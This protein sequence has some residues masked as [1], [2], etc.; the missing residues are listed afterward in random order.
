MSR[1][2]CGVSAFLGDY[3]IVVEHAGRTV[4]TKATVDKLGRTVTINAITPDGAS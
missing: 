4:T 2:F 1:A 3:E